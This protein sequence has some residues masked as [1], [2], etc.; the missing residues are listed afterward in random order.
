MAEKILTGNEP[1]RTE[2]AVEGTTGYSFLN[3]VNGLFVDHTKDKAFQQL[4][5]RF[6]GWTMAFEDLLCDSKRLILQVAMSSELNVLARRLDHI[7]EQHRWSRDFTLESLR[8]GLRE[9]LAAFPVYRT[10]VAQRSNRSRRA[11]PAAG[12]H[13]NS[14]GQAAQPRHQRIGFRLSSKAFSCWSIPAA[15][16]TPSA[17]SG[18]CSPCDSSSF[19]RP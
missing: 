10:Y 15:S 2:W 12:E 19:P 6:T 11:G 16:M 9:V 13:R 17:P 4:Y 8:D 3:L 18:R 5:R 14:R 1:L 7:S